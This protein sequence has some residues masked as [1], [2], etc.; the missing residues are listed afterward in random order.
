SDAQYWPRI[1]GIVGNTRT[2][3]SFR[4][5]ARADVYALGSA[6]SDRSLFAQANGT[7]AMEH[8]R[9]VG[10]DLGYAL[11]D[12]IH[13]VATVNPDFSNVEVDQQTIAPQEFKRPLAEYRPFF[14][15]GAA[16]LTPVSPSAG[17]GQ[18][19]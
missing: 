15:Q 2:R 8:V 12:T 13:V 11:T 7:F 6:G 1:S 5:R 9:S 18:P 19:N 16:F 17:V 14:A 4:E 3:Q 10:A